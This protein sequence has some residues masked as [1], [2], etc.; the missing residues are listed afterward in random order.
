MTYLKNKKNVSFEKK[1][2]YK[3]RLHI[4]NVLQKKKASPLF[5]FFFYL[6][7]KEEKKNKTRNMSNFSHRNSDLII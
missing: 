2:K 5:L 7:E 1:N 4:I 3:F 6:E